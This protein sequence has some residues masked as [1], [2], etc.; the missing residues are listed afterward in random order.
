METVVTVHLTVHYRHPTQPDFFT[1]FLVIRILRFTAGNA[2]RIMAAGII[3]L[4]GYS[5][6]T[7]II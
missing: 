7:W 1:F 5:P 6:I 4:D 3:L 2:Q